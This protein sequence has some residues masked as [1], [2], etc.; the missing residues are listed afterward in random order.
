MKHPGAIESHWIPVEEEYRELDRYEDFLEK[1]RRLLASAANAILD[2]LLQKT[3][4]DVIVENYANRNIS[5]TP[6]VSPEEEEKLLFETSLWMVEHGLF[7]GIENYQLVDD[8]GNVIAIADLAWPD[9]IQTNLS[10]PVA[11]LLNESDNTKRCF[12][13]KGYRYFTDIQDFKSIR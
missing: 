5:A 2:S 6:I 12:N 4:S 7:E 9:G 8:D 3:E 11:I 1:R 10:E 13:Q